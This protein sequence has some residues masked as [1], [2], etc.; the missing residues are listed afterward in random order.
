MDLSRL[1]AAAFLT[2]VMGGVTLRQEIARLSIKTPG[3]TSAWH[4]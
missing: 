1:I 2:F 4:D 3:S